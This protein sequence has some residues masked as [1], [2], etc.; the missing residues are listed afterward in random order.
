MS[1]ISDSGVSS[2]VVRL[3]EGSN[4]V[5]D[6]EI[7]AVDGSLHDFF[8]EEGEKTYFVVAT[9]FFRLRGSRL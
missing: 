8:T 7:S 9:V 1:V 6:L 3:R 4:Y 5:F 2:T